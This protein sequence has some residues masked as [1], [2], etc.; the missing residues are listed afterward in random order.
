M[1]LFLKFRLS[2]ERDNLIQQVKE[3]DK[4]QKEPLHNLK[5]QLLHHERELKD[6]DNIIFELQNEVCTVFQIIT[7]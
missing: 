1:I 3:L 7:V 5:E 2:V 6:K 4:R